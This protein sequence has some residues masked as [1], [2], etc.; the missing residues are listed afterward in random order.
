MKKNRFLL[1]LAALLTALLLVACSDNDTGTDPEEEDP[2]TTQTGD[3]VADGGDEEPELFEIG[4]EPLSL[5]MFGNYDWY[6]MPGWGDDPATA[7]IKELYDIDI[8]SID[9]GGNA[10]QR[11]S[12]MIVDGNLPDFIW[13][14]KGADV[15]RLRAGGV[16]VPLDDYIEKYP[17]LKNWIS[18]DALNMLR[19]ED[20]KIY[21]FP[22]WYN[23]QP[24]GN[25]GWMVNKE[26]YEE[27]GSP[28]LVT[29]DDLYE[30]LKLVQENYPD[31]VPLEVGVNAQGV[32]TIYSAFAEG[33]SPA[34]VGNQV[35]RSGDQLTSLFDSEIY[36]ES[37]KFASKLFR[38][39]LLT[40]DALT[41]TRDDVVEKVH[42]GRVAVFI[43]ASPTDFGG[44]GH[45]Q[46]VRDNPDGGYMFVNPIHK[47]G[48]DPNA[49]HPGD[50]NQTGWNVSVITTSA[51]DPERVFAFL[52]WLTGPEGQ[53]LSMY[54]AEGEYWDGWVEEGVLP[55]F[56]DKYVSDP[57]GLTE[58]NNGTLNFQWNG[59][60]KFLDNA[61][62]AFELQLPE[63][64]INW[65]TFWQHE[66]L[67]ETQK[68][69]TEFV[70]IGPL[71]DSE[72]AIVS[73]RVGEIFEEYRAKA[74]MASSDEDVESVLAEAH[75]QAMAVGYQTLLDWKTEKWQENLDRLG[76]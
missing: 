13:T 40:Q 23:D 42:T 76:N 57:E 44:D 72:E 45:Y 67:W 30:Y 71:P 47:E 1:I 56:T 69:E 5:T 65:T 9:G 55:N 46:L 53:M 52:D 43:G 49:I 16:L 50:Y 29:T 54:G 58:I 6:T 35:A 7:N 63:D 10:A 21:Q 15:E 64:E 41:Q 73:Q 22:N 19:S 8:I 51:E 27:L 28:T 3:D 38:E 48:L 25:A 4:S 39:R 24:F 37:L 70:G 2:D 26:I 74:L 12:T 20:G 36:V 60:S 66:I 34:D 61:K 14:D 59:N 11:L 31:V 75:E 33:F 62:A 17:N 68:D 32:N 18:E